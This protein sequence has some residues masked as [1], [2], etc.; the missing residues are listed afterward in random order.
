MVAIHALLDDGW[1]IPCVY[2][3]LPIKLTTL[4]TSLSALEALEYLPGV[5]LNPLTALADYEHAIRNSVSTI[6]PSTTVHECLFHFKQTI[7]RKTASIGLAPFYKI[8]VEEFLQYMGYIT[9]TPVKRHLVD[10]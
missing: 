7:L 6:W 2:M 1:V 10:E 4:Y 5:N 9:F 3:L 8:K